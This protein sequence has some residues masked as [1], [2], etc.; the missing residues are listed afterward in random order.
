MSTKDLLQL[1][2]PVLAT[3]LGLYFGPRIA[4]SLALRQFHQ[5]KLWEKKVE[6]YQQLLGDM[7]HLC[8]AY[9]SAFDNSVMQGGEQTLESHDELKKAVQTIQRHAYAGGFIISL[10]AEVA[11]QK[12]AGTLTVNMFT[13]AHEAYDAISDSL[14]KNIKVL[15]RD[16]KSTRLT[17]VT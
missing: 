10:E 11:V 6:A 2:V 9:C 14:L 4:V 17:P 13:S 16:R 15:K 8:Q 3:L 1:C 7:S 5:Q 12:C